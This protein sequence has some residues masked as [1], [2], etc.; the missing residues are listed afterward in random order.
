MCH[1]RK[2]TKKSEYEKRVHG[3]EEGCWQGRRGKEGWR[4]KILKMHFI[5]AGIF[6]EQI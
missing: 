6:T 3:E 1:K 5:H 2:Q 4:A